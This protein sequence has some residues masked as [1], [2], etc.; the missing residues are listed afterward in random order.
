MPL[1]KGQPAQ[2]QLLFHSVML[3]LTEAHGIPPGHDVVGDDAAEGVGHN[4]HFASPLLKLGVPG[5][6]KCVQ[7]VQLLG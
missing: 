2:V 4:G 7:S 5:A 1:L 6:E 3:L